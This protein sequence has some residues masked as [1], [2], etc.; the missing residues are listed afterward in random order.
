MLSSRRIGGRFT[1]ALSIPD[2]LAAVWASSIISGTGL[3]GV[4]YDAKS[5]WSGP[6]EFTSDTNMHYSPNGGYLPTGDL[7]LGYSSVPVTLSS[8]TLTGTPVMTNVPTLGSFSDLAVG[9]FKTVFSTY[10]PVTNKNFA[11]GW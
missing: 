2:Q 5:G 4:T 9:T 8:V 11:L 6:R 1:G 3:L 10:L 7:M